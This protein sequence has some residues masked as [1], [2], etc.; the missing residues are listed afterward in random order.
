MSTTEEK[1]YQGWTNYETWA[2]QLWMNNDQGTC[3]HYEELTAQVVKHATYRN[4]FMSKERR[5]VHELAD[6]LKAEHEEQAETFM[7]NQAS[8][9]ADIFNS[10]L[11]S[12]NWYKIAESLIETYHENED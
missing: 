3:E 7:G 1:G 10:A 2:C 9:F 12:V 8:F 11:A 4:E 6:A 5:I